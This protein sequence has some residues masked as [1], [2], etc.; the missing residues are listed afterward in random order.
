MTTEMGIDPAIVAGQVIA[1]VRAG[2]FF[3]PTNDDHRPWLENH[4]EDL[5]ARRL[6]RINEYT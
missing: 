3:I 6:P 1:A 2:E 5:L 4:V